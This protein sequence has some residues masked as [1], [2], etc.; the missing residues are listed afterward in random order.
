MVLSDVNAKNC[1]GKAA[2]DFGHNRL[3]VPPARTTGFIYNPFKSSLIR[4]Y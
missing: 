1:F 4:W 3:P 2:R